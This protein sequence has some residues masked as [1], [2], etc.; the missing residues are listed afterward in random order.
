V[1]STAATD[2]KLLE[3]YRMTGEDLANLKTLSLLGH[4][5]GIEDIVFI[6]KKIRYVRARR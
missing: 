3:T 6:L 5:R 4:L 1:Q 2:K